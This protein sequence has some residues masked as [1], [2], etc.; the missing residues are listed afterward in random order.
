MQA[1]LGVARMTQIYP[2]TTVSCI[3]SQNSKGFRKMQSVDP[4]LFADQLEAAL[5]DHCPTVVKVGMLP[6]ALH[7][8]ILAD[9]LERY[10]HGP[11][12][13]DPVM[14]PSDGEN[15]FFADWW[16]D[17]AVM[18]KFLKHVF[19]MTPNSVEVRRLARPLIDKEGKGEAGEPEV[20]EDVPFDPMDMVSA[21]FLK[22]EYGIKHVLI[23]GGHSKR[24]PYTDFLVSDNDLQQPDEAILPAQA[25]AVTPYE[26]EFIDTPN[27]HGTGCVFS[28]AIACMLAKKMPVERAVHA[29]KMLVQL[30]LKAA[31]GIKFYDNIPGPVYLTLLSPDDESSLSQAPPPMMN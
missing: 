3:T 8:D 25:L 27:T 28:T 19:L 6:S 20:N 26:G 31:K 12:V 22:K 29:A 18:H 30:L 16:E 14:A 2:M 23:T 7:M 11:V 4:V 9:M 10:P 15:N 17:S 24:T 21:Q 13:F 1:D 5:S